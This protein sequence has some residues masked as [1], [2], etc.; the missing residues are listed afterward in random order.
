MP[1]PSIGVHIRYSDRKAPVDRC[2][3]AVRRMLDRLPGAR[4]FLSTDSRLIERSFAEKFGDVIVTEK[5]LPEPGEAAHQ[6]PNCNDPVMNGIEAL[7]DMMLLARCDALVYASRSTFS[8]VSHRVGSFRPGMVTDVD[9]V[10]PG[11]LARR[12]VRRMVS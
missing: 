8:L 10:N 12:V 9:R 6:N 5:W 1:G 11:V 7:R 3:A 2:E 4:I